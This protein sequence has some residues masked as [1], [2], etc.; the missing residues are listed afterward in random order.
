MN[1]KL[2]VLAATAITAATLLAGC[3]SSGDKKE[4][5]QAGSTFVVGMEPTFPPF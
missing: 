4:A 3:G 1:K 2:L 5:D